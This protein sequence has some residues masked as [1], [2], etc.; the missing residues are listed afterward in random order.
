MPII[1]CRT[2]DEERAALTTLRQAHAEMDTQVAVD[3]KWVCF[4][5][6]SYDCPMLETRAFLLG[7]PSFNLDIRKYG[8]RD[9]CDMWAVLTQNGECG[10]AVMARSQKA[11]AARCGCD[12]ADDVDGGQVAALWQAGRHDE[13]ASHC[14]ADIAALGLLYKRKYPNR[15]G[16]LFDLECV[17]V[18]NAADYRQFVKADGRLSDPKKIDADIDAKLGKAGLDPWLAKIVCIGWEVVR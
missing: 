12:V 17:P 2:E 13:I 4:Y 18:D 16:F 8:S 14:R 10:T 15:P 7:L 5:G 1:I 11:L 3:S 9:I 6:L